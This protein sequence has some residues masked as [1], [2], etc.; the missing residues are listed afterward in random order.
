MTILS[1]LSSGRTLSLLPGSD[2]VDLRLRVDGGVA[3]DE[4]RLH[5]S[6]HAEGRVRGQLPTL[7]HHEPLHEHAEPAPQ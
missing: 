4:R 2:D 5:Q 3:E 6:R 7:T 1:I